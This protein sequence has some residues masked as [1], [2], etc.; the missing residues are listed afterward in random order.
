[1]KH[2][3][4]LRLYRGFISEDHIFVNA[5]RKYRDH[6]FWYTLILIILVPFKNYKLW[7]LFGSRG[8]F[9][10]SGKLFHYFHHQINNTWLNERAIEVPIALDCVSNCEG[11]A[12]LEV[13]N[14]LSYYE[15]FDHDILDKY[16]MGEG[17]INE[18]VV[19]FHDRKEREAW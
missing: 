18:D 10:H 14:V 9:E 2:P 11:K 5:Y 8:N 12:I 1:M 15:C 19:D 16:E 7:S 13:G 3:F 17:I 4:F 6:G